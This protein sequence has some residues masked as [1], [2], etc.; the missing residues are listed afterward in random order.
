MCLRSLFPLRP[1]SRDDKSV[2]AGLMWLHL[3]KSCSSAW[4]MNGWVTPE[5][6]AP[7]YSG[8]VMNCS[9]LTFWTVSLFRERKGREVFALRKALDINWLDWPDTT[10]AHGRKAKHPSNIAKKKDT[11]RFLWH[12]HMLHPESWHQYLLFPISTYTPLLVNLFVSAQHSIFIVFL[13]SSPSSSKGTIPWKAESQSDSLAGCCWPTAE[14][15]PASSSRCRRAWRKCSRMRRYSWCYILSVLTN[16]TICGVAG[17]TA[18]ASGK[19]EIILEHCEKGWEIMHHRGRTEHSEPAF[20][21][22]NDT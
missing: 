3:P 9:K 13:S 2:I 22:L 18:C 21:H 12:Q 1:G 5:I 15:S 20:I 11:C 19:K 17:Q 7:G 4:C 14:S 16:W 6:L 8:R 10:E